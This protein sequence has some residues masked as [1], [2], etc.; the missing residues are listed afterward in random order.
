M[1]EIKR[2]QNEIIRIKRDLQSLKDC[3]EQPGED[4]LPHKTAAHMGRLEQGRERLAAAKKALEKA[5]GEYTPDEADIRAAALQENLPFM[6]KLT[7][8]IGGYFGGY[9]TYTVE[10]ADSRI[11]GGRFKYIVDG[12]KSDSILPDPSLIQD[13]GEPVLLIKTLEDLEDYLKSEHDTEDLKKKIQETVE[14]SYI[15]GQKMYEGAQQSQGQ[16]GSVPPGFEE[17]FKAAQQ[18]YGQ[19]PG[20][21]TPPDADYEVV[22]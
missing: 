7:F 6:N 8:E 9:S 20:P 5:G 1:S 3:M 21:Q 12:E 16:T 22:N 17:M 10:A 13:P 15:I 2:I 14:A 19:N 11:Q 18:Q 4:L